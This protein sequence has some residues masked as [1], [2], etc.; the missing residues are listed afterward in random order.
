[1]FTVRSGRHVLALSTATVMIATGLLLSVPAATAAE[2]PDDSPDPT[3]TLPVDAAEG[4]LG[5]DD[6]SDLAV[7]AAAVVPAPVILT[8]TAGPQ[9]SRIVE[10][11][12]T[13]VVGAEVTI[14]IGAPGE[15]PSVRPPVAVG[16]DGTWRLLYYVFLT[17]SDSQVA[18]V[19]HSV[20]DVTSDPATVSFSVP[21]FPQSSAPEFVTPS[22]GETLPAGLVTFAGTGIP[23][24]IVEVF[25]YHA[26]SNHVNPMPATDVWRLAL[27][28][29]EPHE[30]G[31]AIGVAVAADGTW[32]QSM[33]LTDPVDYVA[34]VAHVERMVEYGTWGLLSDVDVLT[35]SL[36]AAG[37]PMLPETG[38]AA[39]NS[40]TALAG[41]AALLLG[42]ALLVRA[43]RRTDS[44]G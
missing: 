24:E 22:E 23:G 39:D 5:P 33:T 31:T 7:D 40:T 36:S 25:V 11:T 3:V 14:S 35:F 15:T 32:T 19:V 34:V 17:E 20:D 29:D 26:D 41:V 37:P 43:R 42:A 4:A 16:A 28:F 2:A 30:P 21:A 27:P 8:P 18:S 6:L 9:L 38:E 13:G 1:M 10:F 12:G 44:V